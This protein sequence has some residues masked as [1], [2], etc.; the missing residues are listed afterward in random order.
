MFKKEPVI[1][2]SLLSRIFFYSLIF[3]GYLFFMSI[4]APLGIS[5]LDYHAERMTNAVN[6]LNLNGFETFG[7]TVWSSCGDCILEG[8]EENA[9]YSSLNG[10]S[11]FP[12][13]L[14]NYFGGIESLLF[15]G[16][17]IDKLFIFI[18]AVLIAEL[19]IKF[20]QDYSSLPDYLIGMACFS[21]FA[22]SPW[23]YKM[24]LDGWWEGLFLM[25]FLFGMVA[26]QNKRFKLGYL[27]FFLAGVFH[28]LWALVISIFYILLII[29][30]YLLPGERKFN[31][32][33]PP[34]IVSP[35]MNMKLIFA[36]ALSSI[37]FF[38]SQFLASQYFVFGSGSSVFFRMGI[39]GNDIYNGGLIGALQFLG[40]SRF[41]QCFQG[42]G[43]EAF[44]GSTMV[45][46][47]M[48]NCLFSIAGMGIISLIAIFGAYLLIKNSTLAMQTLIPLIF[49]LL[50]FIGVF[51]QSMS[52]HLMGYSYIFSAIFSVGITYL[53]LVLQKSSGSN[54][55]GFI[56]SIPCLA[57]ILILSLRVSML[58]GMS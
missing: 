18:G 27:V 34:N 33:F 35:N 8:L 19:M 37:I 42:M 45:I 52:V 25:C 43:M 21:L 40:G 3:L 30:S 16:P 48:Y 20:I 51:Q 29:S 53:M 46:I 55:L 10:I 28:H 38:L 26:F 47:A 58:S 24:F 22:L 15:F 4:Y 49:A 23:T 13:I 54:L 7:F 6:F 39:S 44:S 41:T 2:M 9:M 31:K 56:F 1:K 11:L 36:L 12:Y 5:W 14:L 57:G 17:M 50:F 32:Y